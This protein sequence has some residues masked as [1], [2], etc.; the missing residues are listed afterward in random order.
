[1]SAA[2]DVGEHLPAAPTVGATAVDS[3]LQVGVPAQVMEDL[4]KKKRG[5]LAD[6]SHA[7]GR[8]SRATAG[9]RPGF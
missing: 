5:T 8:T 4:W 3:A 6:G 9:G 1:M 2:I 7:V